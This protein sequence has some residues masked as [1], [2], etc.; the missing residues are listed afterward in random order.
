MTLA[1][2]AA[3]AVLV[4]VAAWSVREWLRA[5]AFVLGLLS[6]DPPA[7]PPRPRPPLGLEQLG[8]MILE[9]EKAVIEEALA[10]WRRRQGTHEGNLL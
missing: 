2:A 1:T 5:A 3:A 7:A 10:D 4:A 9:D 8:S 6:I